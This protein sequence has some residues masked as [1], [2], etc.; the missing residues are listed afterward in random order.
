MKLSPHFTL[1]ELTVTSHH[2]IDNTPDD[3]AKFHLVAL[4]NTVLEVIRE[5]FGP[6][7]ITSGYRSLALNAA[8]PGSAKDSAHCYGC[9]AD[10]QSIN[11]HSPADMARWVRDE[12][13]I[14]YDQVI[15]E[16]KG[17]GRWMHL[18]MLRPGHEHAPRKQALRYK[19]GI[20]TVL[21]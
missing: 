15:D 5:K 18:G 14:D 17:N 21:A 9:A 19:D 6:L 1:E 7:R 11:G 16:Q 3:D 2:G 8:V 10:I 13:G 12:S 4:A 20:W